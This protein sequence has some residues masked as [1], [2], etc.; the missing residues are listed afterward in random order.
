M[1]ASLVRAA[2]AGVALFSVPA[3]HAQSR[4]TPPLLAPGPKECPPD[5]SKPPR[6]T[7][8]SAPLSD[9]LSESKGVICPPARVDPSIV[10]DPPATN[11]SMPVI[12]PPGTP[13]GDP[14]IVPK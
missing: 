12:S 8:G 1:R 7:S 9:Q 3:A 2:L 13:G 6:E 4:T 5:V 11:G 10:V 14:S